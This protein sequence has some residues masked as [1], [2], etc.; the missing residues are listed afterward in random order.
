MVI[1]GH[2]KGTAV[3]P[4]RTIDILF[5]LPDRLRTDFGAAATTQ[6]ELLAVLAE[7]YAAVTRERDGWITVAPGRR[8]P[9]SVAVRVLPAFA[10][11]TGG[12][13]VAQT[14]RQRANGA[15]YHVHPQAESLALARADAA[16]SGKASHLIRMLKCWRLAHGV[17]VSPLVLERLAVAFAHAWI[18]QRR[19]LLFYDWMVR[20]FFFWM[21]AQAGQPLRAPGTL[22]QVWAGDAWRA[23]AWEAYRRAADAA[24]LERDNRL[25]EALT[26]WRTVFGRAFPAE[27]AST[28]P[29]RPL[30]PALAA[31]SAPQVRRGGAAASADL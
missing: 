15:W 17:A 7:R 10:C 25:G 1:G 8:T 2:G 27:P 22:E 3:R 23:D 12:Y 24:A 30:P 6:S 5:V 28:T 11:D 13:L 14:S 20:D 18:Y 31:R 16:T 29:N 9:E 21:V 4:A 26:A 19:S